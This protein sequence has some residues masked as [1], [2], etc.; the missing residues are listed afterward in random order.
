[1]LNTWAIQGLYGCKHG[2][3]RDDTVGIQAI[4]IHGLYM[5]YAWSIRVYMWNKPC[6]QR[7]YIC[8][9]RGPYGSFTGSSQGLHRDYLGIIGCIH[10]LYFAYVWSIQGIYSHYTWCIQGL[11]WGY[12]GSLQETKRVHSESVQRLSIT[13]HRL[14]RDLTK[15]MKDL[16]RS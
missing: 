15:T 2:L 5:G 4:S 9:L 14:W 13:N 10:R 12:T 7:I 16:Y 6:L 1:M 11:Y 3:Y 8:I